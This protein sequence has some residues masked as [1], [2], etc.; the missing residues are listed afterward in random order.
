MPK[1]T[2]LGWFPLLVIA[3][4]AAGAAGLLLIDRGANPFVEPTEESLGVTPK[5]DAIPFD[6]DSAYKYL[7]ALCAIGPRPSGSKGMTEQQELI[8]KHFTDLGASVQKQVF[9]VRHPLDGSAVEMANIIVSWNPEAK[10]RYLVCTHYDTRPFPDRDPANP[11]GRFV[12]ANDGGSSSALLMELGRH[13]NQLRGKNGVDFI[14]FDGEELVFNEN[15]PYFYGSKHFAQEYRMQPPAYRYRQ[16]L[17]LDMVGDADLVIRQEVNSARLA[18]YVV[19]DVWGAAKRLGVR[20]FEERLG[21]TVSDDHLP[22]NEVAKIP[23]ADLIDFEYPYWHTEQDT[24][25]KCS[26]ASLEKVGKVTYE[27]LRANVNR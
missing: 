27:W 10:T 23:T 24:P 21:P 25:D 13:M 17:L 26:A 7:E 8:V 3:V 22:L 18:R 20:E 14:Y 9:K 1:M 15:D 5:F 11:K 4:A 2:R 12:G 19:G 16:G 6:G